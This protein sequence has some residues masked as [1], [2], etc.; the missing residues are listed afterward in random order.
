MGTGSRP[1][2]CWTCFCCSFSHS[3]SSAFGASSPQLSLFLPFGISYHEPGAPRFIWLALIIPLALLKVVPAGWGRRIVEITKWALIV[4]LILVAA[5]FISK[6]VQQALFP[7]LED[8]GRP[9]FGT[10]AEFGASA[11]A[12][13]ATAPNAPRSAVRG[14]RPRS[15]PATD[16]GAGRTHASA[17]R[18][19]KR[20]TQS[21]LRRLG[22]FFGLRQIQPSSMMQKPVFKPGPGVPDWTWRT[23]TFGWNGPVA[24]SQQ[25]RP[26]LISVG[27]ERVLTILRIVLLLALAAILLDA[28]RWGG[29]VF[30]GAGKAAVW[31]AF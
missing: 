6:Q 26:I 12:M 18:P 7:Q 29:S 23:V 1:G 17:I 13:N 4:I 5:P 14:G 3:P 19:W 16:G 30:R 22:V 31:V 15:G 27:L 21:L 11:D 25:V 2:H 10:A 24:A 28:R 8:V 20:T 9:N